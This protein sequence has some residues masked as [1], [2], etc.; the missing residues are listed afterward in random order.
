MRDVPV[1]A[2]PAPA[3]PGVFL[4]RCALPL[5]CGAVLLTSCGTGAGGEGED[6][7]LPGVPMGVTAEAGSATT[8]HVMWNALDGA[9]TYE[10]YRG[11]TLVK[12]VPASD[13]MVDVTRLRPSTAYA[14][15]VRARDSDGR[16]GPRSR[17]VRA[18]TPAAVT[19]ASAPTRP[20]GAEGRAAGGRAVQ[21]TWS[22]S[23][24]DRK[25]VS[26]DVYQGGTKVHSV[27]GAQTAAV[28]T[29][30]RPGTRYTFTVRARDAADNLSPASAVV[31]LSTP[32][33][34]DGRASAPTALRAAS[35]LADGAYYLDLT[36]VP[37]RT[38]GPVA[39]YQIHLDG[40]PATSLVYG[41]EAPRDR[42][43]YSFYAGREAGVTHRVRVR[44]RLADGTWGGFSE[45]REVTLGA[46]G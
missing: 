37:P 36:W 6:G 17:E 3:A 13:R 24:D 38:D 31:R 45:E 21:L 8:V 25:V 28:V 34:D 23:K 41:A 7:G 1:P 27:G 18:T 12:K 14:F 44:A 15:T 33:S 39:E 43:E 20:E 10:V 22:A 9:E 29:G 35:H 30:L 2:V 16:L 26:Y 40:R 5:L 19:D 42:A 32:G 46:G 4:R 11:G